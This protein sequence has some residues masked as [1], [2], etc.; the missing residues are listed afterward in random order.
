MLNMLI[1]V[2]AAQNRKRTEGV[3]K[4]WAND[5]KK[6]ACTGL[7]MSAGPR[8]EF[9]I[10]KKNFA[11]VMPIADRRRCARMGSPNLLNS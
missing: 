10:E 11:A 3:P 4:A 2:D 7:L 1:D 8:K 9:E 5:G 6:V